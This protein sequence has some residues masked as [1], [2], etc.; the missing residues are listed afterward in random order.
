VED[1]ILHTRESE[2]RM[3]FH[4][5]APCRVLLFLMDWQPSWAELRGCKWQEHQKGFRMDGNRRTA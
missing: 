1:E 3:D 5:E 2:S 4:P